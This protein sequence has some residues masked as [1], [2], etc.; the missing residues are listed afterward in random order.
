MWIDIRYTPW[1]DTIDVCFIF[2]VY[3]VL[4]TIG[5]YDYDHYHRRIQLVERE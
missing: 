5:L 1:G 4:L 2:I 3:F